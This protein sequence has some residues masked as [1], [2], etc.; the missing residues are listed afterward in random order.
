MIESEFL[1]ITPA[2]DQGE[3]RRRGDDTSNGMRKG[4]LLN[5]SFRIPQNVIV[6]R[7]CRYYDAVC[8][9]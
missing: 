9:N 8:L 5:V 1:M 7:M 2:N 6:L 4:V 3:R